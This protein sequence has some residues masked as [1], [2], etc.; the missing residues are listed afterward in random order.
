MLD[1]VN[2]V[3]KEYFYYLIGFVEFV[4]SEFIMLVLIFLFNLG[5]KVAEV[6]SEAAL[7]RRRQFYLQKKMGDLFRMLICRRDSYHVLFNVL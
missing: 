6:G 7:G 5:S 4:V 1:A 2:I 3:N